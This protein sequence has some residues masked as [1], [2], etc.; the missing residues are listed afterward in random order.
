[1]L[2]CSLD[3]ATKLTDEPARQLPLDDSHAR[4]FERQGRRFDES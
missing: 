1:M 2:L 3:V 4:A